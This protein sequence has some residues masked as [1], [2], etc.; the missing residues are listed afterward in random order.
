MSKERILELK[1]ISSDIY[2]FFS[3]NNSII[4]IS[5]IL[6]SIV[7]IYF[8]NKINLKYLLDFMVLSG[9]LL[10]LYIFIAPHRYYALANFLTYAFR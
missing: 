3:D 7:Y 6:L 9:V 5:I 8:R 1:N 4:I 2:T 10:A